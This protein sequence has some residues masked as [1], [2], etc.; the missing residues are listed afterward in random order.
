LHLEL[1]QNLHH[2]PFSNI[3]SDIVGYFQEKSKISDNRITAL[4]RKIN[5]V[6]TLPIQML[7]LV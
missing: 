6:T 1:L 7:V 2:S 3:R 4:K 5:P